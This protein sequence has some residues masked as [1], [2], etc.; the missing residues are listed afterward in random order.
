MTKG[1]SNEVGY[2]YRDGFWDDSKVPTRDGESVE[3]ILVKY[4][5]GKIFPFCEYDYFSGKIRISGKNF[6]K[7]KIQNQKL[8]INQLHEDLDKKFKYSILVPV[9]DFNGL[10]KPHKL[11]ILKDFLYDPDLG[12]I[13]S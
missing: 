13:W 1:F 6:L 3:V 9:E 11:S 7:H 8:F 5:D 10:L 12:L 2:Q 4:K